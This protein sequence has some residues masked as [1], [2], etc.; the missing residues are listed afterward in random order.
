MDLQTHENSL[1]HYNK[2]KQTMKMQENK[3]TKSH[4][5]A[6]IIY[7]IVVLE[8]TSLLHQ[9]MFMSEYLYMMST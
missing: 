7:V 5:Y 4:K 2:H 3:L 9:I 1:K 8:H 6:P